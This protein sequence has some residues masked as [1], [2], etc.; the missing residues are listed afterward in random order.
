MLN[1]RTVL[2]NNYYVNLLIFNIL[3]NE[4]KYKILIHQIKPHPFFP[5]VYEKPSL[6]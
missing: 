5:L 6:I 2:F 3:F 1:Q 4:I